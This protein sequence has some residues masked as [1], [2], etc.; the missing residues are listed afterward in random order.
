MMKKIWS[1]S[2][3]LGQLGRQRVHIV[4]PQRQHQNGECRAL[5]IKDRFAVIFCGSGHVALR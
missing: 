5:Q 4:P 1:L 2:D 3:F